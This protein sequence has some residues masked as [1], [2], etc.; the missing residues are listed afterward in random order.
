[1][2]EPLDDAARV[3]GFHHAID[4]LPPLIRRFIDEDRHAG[5]S[6]GGPSN[7]QKEPSCISDN[8]PRYLPA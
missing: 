6:L 5:A 8:G 4:G 7:G 1:M 3:G 2:L